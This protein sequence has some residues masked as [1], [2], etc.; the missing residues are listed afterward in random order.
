MSIAF[1]NFNG[2]I[3][4]INPINNG[5]Q[6]IL[7]E[8]AGTQRILHRLGVFG[9]QANAFKLIAR[10]GKRIGVRT[11]VKYVKKNGQFYTNFN[12]THIQEPELNDSAK[13]FF[14]GFFTT[15]NMIM[16]GYVINLIEPKHDRLS[17]NPVFHR[18]TVLGK[19]AEAIRPKLVR[20][21][22]FDAHCDIR[23]ARVKGRF[24]TNFPVTAWKRIPKVEK[25]KPKKQETVI[26]DDFF[27]PEIDNTKTQYDRRYEGL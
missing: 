9:N 15:F 26:D 12:V 16:D 3:G 5:F 24:F 17:S 8:M 23:Y 7:I 21:T 19:T 14:T 18:I 13:A 27:V 20:G 1:A 25:D 11:S 2:T 6:F 22:R 10:K 4:N